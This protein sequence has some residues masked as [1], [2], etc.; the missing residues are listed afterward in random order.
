MK[1][2][3]LFSGQGAQ[4]PGMGKELYENY[5]CAKEI[6]DSVHVDFD[7]KKLCFEGPTET[8][9][10]TQY[11]QACIFV[12]SVACARVLNECGIYAN[13]SAG[14]SLGEYSA[15]SYGEV[16]SVNDGANIVR[17]RGKIMANALPLGTTS[18]AAVLMLDERSIK[19]AC[20]EV[21]SIGICEIANYNC[22]GQ[23]VITG[24]NE[25]LKACSQ[26]CLEK[27][28]RKVMPLQTSGA[29][30]SSLLKEASHHLREVLTNYDLKPSKIPVY[31][32]ISGTILNDSYLSIL[33]KQIA[34]SVYF[35]QTISNMLKDGVDTFIEVGPGSTISGFVKKCTKGMDVK[36]LHVEDQASL[37]ETLNKLKGN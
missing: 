5:P 22:P 4:Y 19:D 15:L 23:I 27:G 37:D 12:T 25:A 1:I 13:V 16:C 32:N 26:K 29:F 11:A 28:A 17:A 35:E 3:F 36:I 7:L 31:H 33:S 2:A 8:L 10:D 24:E 34:S 18:M 21:S 9:N 14:L 20:N 30:H 6:F